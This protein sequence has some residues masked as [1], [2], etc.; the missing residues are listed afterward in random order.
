MPI[1]IFDLYE[2]LKKHV[3]DE[4][5]DAFYNATE[6]AAQFDIVKEMLEIL[7]KAVTK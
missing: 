2:D 3:G 7:I 6:G 1:D 4:Y 5:D